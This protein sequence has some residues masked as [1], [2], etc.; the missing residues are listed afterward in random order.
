MFS[1]NISM[2]RQLKNPHLFCYDNVKFSL[3]NQ[4]GRKNEINFK[5]NYGKIMHLIYIGNKL[6]KL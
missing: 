5:G 6:E 2:S 1:L 4:L 3:K